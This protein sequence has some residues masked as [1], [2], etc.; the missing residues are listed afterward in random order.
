MTDPGQAYSLL[1][2][3]LANK[4]LSGTAALRR[5]NAFFSNQQSER[6]IVLLL[7]ELDFLLLKKSSILY[8]FFEWT[9]MEQSKLIVVA[10]ANT[11]DL[12]ERYLPNRIASR[13][14]SNR[15]NFKP[16]MYPQLMAIINHHLAAHH[17]NLFHPDAIEYC[18]RKVSS[19][20][21]D[22][23]RALSL[24]KRAI[25]WVSRQPQVLGSSKLI[26]IPIMDAAI[27]H[28]FS[29][30][31][32]QVIRDLSLKQQM[33]LIS[34]LLMAKVTGSSLVGFE[35]AC[36]RFWQ[37]EIVLQSGNLSPYEV[38]LR[39]YH[40][41]EVFRLL[42]RQDGGRKTL[43]MAST[44]IKLAVPEEEV[45]LALKEIDEFKSILQNT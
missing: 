6:P 21:G 12:P 20:S 31:L 14:G 42:I 7:D 18:A 17:R 27:Q 40:S 37:L 9:G 35:G 29:G 43:I 4:T 5:L 11:M 15:I 36:D 22:A 38:L 2:R 24:A 25:E 34:V 8:H 3:F 13:M 28:T 45:R 41:L 30:N 44:M 16:Y 33:F 1:W 39:L 19:I 10:I 23:R 32:V 26:T